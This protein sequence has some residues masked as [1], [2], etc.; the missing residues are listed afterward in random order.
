MKEYTQKD[1]NVIIQVVIPL[2]IE[3]NLQYMFHKLLLVYVPPEEQVH[4]L[5]ERDHISREMAQSILAAQLPIEE[6]KAYADFIV[7]NSRSLQ[8]TKGQ[9][10]EVWQKLKEFQEE[11]RKA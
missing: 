11:R 9:V 2:L 10:A 3:A 6:K 5:M 7:D 8:E 4:R 1:P